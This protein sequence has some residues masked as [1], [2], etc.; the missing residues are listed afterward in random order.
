MID[1]VASL[2]LSQQDAAGMF[3]NETLASGSGSSSG[4]TFCGATPLLLEKQRVLNW[5]SALCWNS[6][7]AETG[8]WGLISRKQT[9]KEFSCCLSKVWSVLVQMRDWG[10]LG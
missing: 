5:V 4:L 1:S 3:C 2:Q 7:N 8:S 9:G 6:C 10:S